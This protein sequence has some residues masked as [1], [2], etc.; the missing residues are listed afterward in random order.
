MK[1]ATRA[2]LYRI[3]LAVLPLLTLWGVVSDQ[4]GPLVIALVAAILG[5]GL[6]AKNTSTDSEES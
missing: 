6:A 3:A 1:E 4:E 5:V 2:Y